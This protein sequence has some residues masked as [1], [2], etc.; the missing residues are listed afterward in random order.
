MLRRVYL[1]LFVFCFLVS[2]AS[3]QVVYDARIGY[4]EILT[5]AP[6]DYPVINGP[7]IYGARPGKKFIYRIPC[8]GKRPIEFKVEELPAGLTLDTEAGIIYGISPAEAGEYNMT[9]VAQN[10]VGQATRS[11]KLVI[12]DKL[13]LTPL[14]GWNSWGGHMV[15]VSDRI[16]RRAADIFVQ[17]GLAD[18]GFQYIGIDDCWTIDTSDKINMVI[19]GKPSER[20]FDGLDYRQLLEGTRDARGDILTNDRFPDMKALTDYVHGYGLK[21][22]I[23]SS[24]GELTCQ[25]YPGSRHHEKQ[26]AS[27][28]AAWGFDLLKY[29]QCGPGSALLRKKRKENPDY[30]YADFWKPMADYLQ[31]QDRDIVYNLCQYGWDDPWTWAPAIDIQTWRTGGDLNH[32]V[33]EYF[34]QGVR[35]ATTLRQYS[36]PGQWSDPDFMYLGKIRDFKDKTAPSKA[37]PLSTNQQY[38]YVTLWSVIAAPFFLSCDIEAIDDFTVGLMANAGVVNI[39]QDELGYVGRVIRDEN[40]QVVI[41]KQLAD[42]ARAVAIFNTN[43]KEEALVHL[44]WDE[45]GHCCEQEV[46]DVWRGK[47]LG[48]QK[49]GMTVR[50]SPN[51]VA[52]F[53]VREV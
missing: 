22:G 5:P 28:Y 19:D 41:V 36:K 39:N 46:Y 14:T 1:P 3:A 11:F 9:F 49:V 15:A 51:G 52:Y 2:L 21:M 38:Q 6:A 16:I 53:I 20:R 26:D 48:M 30:K 47:D 7:K 23:Y 8:Q 37:I 24:P 45:L 4:H 13:A 35:L 10:Q 17:R 32:H 42:G 40:D 34:E 33:E 12:G 27:R 29:D 44:D 50:L 25:K 43:P 18:V 31:M